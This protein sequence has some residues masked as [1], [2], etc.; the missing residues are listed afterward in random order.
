MTKGVQTRSHGRAAHTNKIL[1]TVSAMVNVV[2][3]LFSGYTAYRAAELDAVKKILKI[4]CLFR[5]TPR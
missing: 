2:L 1:L 3:A 4:S 5:R